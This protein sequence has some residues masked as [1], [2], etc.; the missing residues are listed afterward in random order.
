MSVYNHYRRELS[1]RDQRLIREV[2]KQVFVNLVLR[3]VEV[4][5]VESKPVFNISVNVHQIVKSDDDARDVNIVKLKRELE[6]LQRELEKSLAENVALKQELEKLK[7]QR[8]E[9]QNQLQHLQQHQSVSFK[10]RDAVFALLVVKACIEKHSCDPGKLLDFLS[11]ELAR[12]RT[13]QISESFIES[14]VKQL[15]K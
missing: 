15:V 4:Q 3:R 5:H 6:R 14:Y 11:K 9:L 13:V 2:L 10:Y 8:E 12:H 1:A 7:R